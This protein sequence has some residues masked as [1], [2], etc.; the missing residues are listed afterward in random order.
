MP[1][2]RAKPAAPAG[3]RGYDRFNVV[4]PI[5]T[6]TNVYGGAYENMALLTYSGLQSEADGLFY[7]AA[8]AGWSVR[9]DSASG[10]FAVST[11]SAGEYKVF[12][13]T[14]GYLILSDTVYSKY[15]AGTYEYYVA[16][17]N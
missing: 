16:L 11:G 14:G 13:A 12:P 2:T 1:A 4:A 8:P 7:F 9:A 3:I 15:P 5:A 17:V 6:V 10:T